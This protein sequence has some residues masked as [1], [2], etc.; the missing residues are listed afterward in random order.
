MEA[1]ARGC[2]G[3]G[4]KGKVTGRASSQG[5]KDHAVHSLGNQVQSWD[6]DRTTIGR[7]IPT[8]VRLGWGQTSWQFRRARCRTAA[9]RRRQDML[10][11]HRPCFISSC[12]ITISCSSQQDC[13]HTPPLVARLRGPT[14]LHPPPP[15]PALDPQAGMKEACRARPVVSKSRNSCAVE[16]EWTP[17]H[18]ATR[19][20]GPPGSTCFVPCKSQRT[21]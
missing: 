4:R 11:R 10:E 5:L 17:S 9:Y 21:T 16:V 19:E 12:S 18:A 14:W 8:H 20:A 7:F 2:R 6:V 1:P 15:S 3:Q 13:A